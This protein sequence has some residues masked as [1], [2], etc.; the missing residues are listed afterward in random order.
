MVYRKGERV[1]AKE[2]RPYTPEHPVARLIA[3]GDGW[4]LAWVCQMCTPW[5]TVSRKT[6]IAVERIGELDRGEEPTEEE[7][8]KLAALWWTTP[9]GLRKSIKDA[10]PATEA[11]R[12]KLASFGIVRS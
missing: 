8:E 1:I 12:A 10:R 5:E 7:V 2:V 3:D 6:K 11:R 9:T 4:V